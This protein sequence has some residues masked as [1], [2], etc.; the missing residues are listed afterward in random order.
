[1]ADQILSADVD[2]LSYLDPTMEKSDLATVRDKFRGRVALAG[3]ISS[4]VTLFGGSREGI[5]QAVHTA[6][7]QL[8]PCGFILAPV[9]SLTPDTPWSSVETMIEAWKEV[10]D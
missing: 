9:C 4:A 2:L 8:G 3:G 10:R 1:M 6:V 5:R 7:Q